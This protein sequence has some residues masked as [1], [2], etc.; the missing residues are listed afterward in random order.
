MTRPD[1]KFDTRM[2]MNLLM[3]VKN[4]N[5]KLL[6][7]PNKEISSFDVLSQII[8]PMSAHFKN[9]QNNDDKNNIIDITSGKYSKG[10]LDKSALGSGKGLI[11]NIFNDFVSGA[12]DFIDNLQ[13]IV[14]DYMKLSSYSVG[15]SDLISNNN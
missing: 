1:I 2:A 12:S 7:N 14:T 9:G 11:Q 3:S 6:K 15:I 5:P 10:Q 13:N 4:V 8:P